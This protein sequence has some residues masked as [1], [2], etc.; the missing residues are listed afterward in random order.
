MT[1]KSNRETTHL[2]DHLDF[3][4]IAKQ[5]NALK[6][7]IFDA[8]EPNETKLQLIKE[9]LST[10]CYTIQSNHIAAKLLEHIHQN[11]EVEFA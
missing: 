6:A 7:A 9:A 3:N 1:N 4:D 11:D 2:M 8:I 5:M 10:S